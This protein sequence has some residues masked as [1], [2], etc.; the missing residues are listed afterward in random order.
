MSRLVA[1]L[2]TKSRPSHRSPWLEDEFVECYAR[3]RAAS[4]AVRVWY[5]RWREADPDVG[6]PAYV[7]YV[8]ALDYEEHAAAV[9]REC[10]DRIATQCG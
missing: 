6:A 3:W 10:A 9:Y 4:L 5:D 8:A 2:R 7:A 1:S